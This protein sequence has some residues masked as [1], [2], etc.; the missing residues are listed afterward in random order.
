MSGKTYNPETRTW[1]G[2]VVPS[3][4]NTN[5]GVGQLVLR[6][7][8]NSPGFV[9]Q[10]NADTDKRTTCFEMRMRIIRIAIQLS[11]L[12]YKKGDIVAIMASNSEFCGAL[13][14][15][16]FVLGMPVNFLSPNFNKADIDHMLGI[17]HPRLIFCDSNLV[18][19]MKRAVADLNLASP[20]YTLLEKIEGYGFLEDFLV[21]TKD[22]SDFS[23]PD[24]GDV[25]RLAA[26][27]MCSSGTT[28][29]S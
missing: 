1:K 24:L 25:S 22:E 2:P 15:A 26:V 8:E 28:G 9:S 20:I 16:C 23:A 19:I 27:I 29:V 6:V 14:F 18:G 12:G 10:I 11:K 13:A 21:E 7:F 5:I 3:I 17:T 4:Y